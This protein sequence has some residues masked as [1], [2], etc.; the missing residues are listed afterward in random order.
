[1]SLKKKTFRDFSLSILCFFIGRSVHPF[2]CGVHRSDVRLTSRFI[3]GEIFDGIYSVV[4]ECGHG[5]YEQGLPVDFCNQPVG[6]PLGMATHESQSLFWERL[7]GQSR[8]FCH[9][10]TPRIN[11]LF[12]TEPYGTA[13]TATPSA[14]DWYAA[15]NKV[16]PTL[17]RLDADELTYHAHIL[18]RYEIERDLMSGR[19]PVEAGP[20]RQTWEK[21]MREYVGLVPDN[22]VDGALQDVHWG[23]TSI[24]YFPSYSLGALVAIQL[25]EKMR[26]EMPDLEEVVSNPARSL[27]P[28]RD[29]LCEK[30]HSR[31]KLDGNLDELLIKATGETLNPT[32]AINYY[33]KKYTELYG[34]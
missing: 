21:Y 1:M 28:I 26:T 4:H 13:A 16:Q 23:T 7:I 12:G 32:Y 14:D 9:R 31:G 15:V 3:D 8:W 34:L 19:L 10:V 33:K 6:Q 30:V 18:V 24:G 29:W 27:V 17:K 2:T 5:L 22:D 11:E 25:F 20:I